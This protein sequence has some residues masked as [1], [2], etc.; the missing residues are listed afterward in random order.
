MGTANCLLPMASH[1][2]M[3]PVC[4]FSYI[5]LDLFNATPMLIKPTESTES[6]YSAAEESERSSSSLNPEGIEFASDSNPLQP[7]SWQSEASS[8]DHL[9]KVWT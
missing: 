7:P 1:T 6:L 5:P 2:Y 4:A 8:V 3:S 9:H